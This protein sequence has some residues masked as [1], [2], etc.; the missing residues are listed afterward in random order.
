MSTRDIIHEFSEKPSLILTYF[1]FM[2]TVF[3]TTSLLTWLP[4]YF[5]GCMT[6]HQK[7]LGPKHL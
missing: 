2:A 7:P 1:G 3:V 4:S 5:E 6:L